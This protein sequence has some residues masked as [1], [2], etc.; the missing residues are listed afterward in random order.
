MAR[1]LMILFAFLAVF[2]HVAA[3]MVFLRATA[4]GMGHVTVHVQ[5]LGHHHLDDGLMQLDDKQAPTFHVHLGEA[6]CDHHDLVPELP[7]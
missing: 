3:V 6:S 5:E 1:K 2:S 7:A 4:N